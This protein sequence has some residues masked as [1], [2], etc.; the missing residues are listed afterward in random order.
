MEQPPEQKRF[1]PSGVDAQS[2]MGFEQ[3]IQD[4]RFKALLETAKS[5]LAA[6]DVTGT[7]AALDEA[8]ELRPSAPELDY[9]ER[10]LSALIPGSARAAAGPSHARPLSAVA[11]LVL[12]IS[13]VTG[14]DYMRS[15][16]PPP[17]T[18]LS[19]TLAL[20]HVV[21]P[22]ASA[23][24]AAEAL[25]APA[26]PLRAIGTS[27]IDRRFEDE[28]V[29]PETRRPAVDTPEPLPAG[30]VS[31]DFVYPSAPRELMPRSSRSVP[32]SPLSTLSR[33]TAVIAPSALTPSASP[34][35]QPP[36]VAVPPIAPM[37]SSAGQDQREVSDVLNA[38]ARAYGRL[39]AGAARQVWPTVNERA[40]SRAFASLS[41]QDIAFDDCRIDVRGGTASADCSGRASYTGKVGSREPRTEARQWHFELR[42]DGA[43]WKI[44]TADMR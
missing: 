6:K 3:R 34:A 38:Y 35:V 28:L 11:L 26:L 15:A 9:I 37:P 42:R 5:S 40:L 13:L 20:P 16:A 21:Q 10:R 7:R 22:V 18:R 19:P 24:V 4:R 27:G 36:A 1:V 32:L 29:V 25:A 43:E 44:A 39:D 31:D 12:G 17:V 41:S 2:W 30:E 14:L 8:R 33:G 23:E